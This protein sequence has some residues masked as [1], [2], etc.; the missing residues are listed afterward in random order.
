MNFLKNSSSGVFFVACSRHESRRKKLNGETRNGAP[1]MPMPRFHGSGNLHRSQKRATGTI[2]RDE[3]SRSR[4]AQ[5]G[6]GQT[7]GFFSHYLR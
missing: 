2:R 6:G 4:N 1:S 5:T 3:W 7:R